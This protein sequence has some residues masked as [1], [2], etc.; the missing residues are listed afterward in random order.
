MGI[1]KRRWGGRGEEARQAYNTY[2]PSKRKETYLAWILLT[3]ANIAGP[4]PESVSIFNDSIAMF[5]EKS[6]P[7]GPEPPANQSF[8]ARWDSS[9][10]EWV[11]S[12]LK[13]AI[14]YVATNHMNMLLELRLD[15]HLRQIPKDDSHEPS[16][17]PRR[18]VW[19][20]GENVF[21]D[22]DRHQWA[23]GVV[24]DWTKIV[25]LVGI[26][27][28][29]ILTHNKDHRQHSESPPQAS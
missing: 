25:G 9:W 15:Q 22:D 2:P 18:V 8:L 6:A 3:Y 11:G 4:A 28:I 10:E 26:L 14:V 23:F 29:Y 1:R 27:G 12:E 13:E 5:I 24:E 17:K 7:V 19:H 16:K 21:V 20:Q